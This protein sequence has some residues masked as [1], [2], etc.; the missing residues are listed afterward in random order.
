MSELKYNSAV[1]LKA[2]QEGKTIFGSAVV[3]DL[4]QEIQDLRAKREATEQTLK[5]SR[6]L[7]K[8]PISHDMIIESRRERD[9]LQAKLNH[10]A[11]QWKDSQYKIKLLN[12]ALRAANNGNET[13][14][15][16]YAYEPDK[17]IE[18]LKTVCNGVIVHIPVDWLNEII[19]ELTAR[20]EKA[21]A[22]VKALAENA[23]QDTELLDEILGGALKE[24]CVY[25]KNELIDWTFHCCD[26]STVS[27]KIAKRIG[28]NLG[29]HQPESIARDREVT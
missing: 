14:D 24:S 26:W 4:L 9:N 15:L 17:G 12:M 6:N 28:V 25:R 21:E 20:A 5:E 2:R 18:Q 11:D 22:T 16:R 3:D 27:K 8:S 10:V 23:K 19:A 13:D 29:E 7:C 1:I